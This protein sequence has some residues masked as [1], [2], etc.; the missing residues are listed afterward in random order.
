MAMNW[1][2]AL[3]TAMRSRTDQVLEKRE[4][5]QEKQKQMEMIQQVMFG[6]P[7]QTGPKTTQIDPAQGFGG[8][9]NWDTTVRK[10]AQA[11]LFPDA[12]PA[13][14]QYLTMNPNLAGDLI[15][16]Q[17]AEKLK[18]A[19]SENVLGVPAA[20]WNKLTPEQQDLAVKKKLNIDGDT[21][22]LKPSERYRVVG[23][24]LVDLSG[25][26]GKPVVAL[27][28]E[29]GPEGLEL[30]DRIEAENKLRDD[31][32]AISK[33]FRAVRDSFARIKGAGADPT[34]AG[35]LALIFNYMKLLDPGSVVRESEFAVAERAGGMRDRA[36][37]FVEKI[38]NG[39]RLSPQQ[40]ADFMQRAQ[41]L[42]ASM[43]GIYGEVEN[44]YTGMATR[45]GLDPQNV[46]T[47]YKGASEPGEW[48]STPSGTNYRVVE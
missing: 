47:S 29:Q 9:V 39:Q 13:M 15:K 31:F 35:D 26:E 25:P 24:R 38:R 2:D 14:K 18:G 21:A 16:T 43:Q 10:P 1:L 23:D 40:R 36:E 4:A 32:N 34:A 37:A 12:S 44:E 33:D 46:V 7:A 42:F 48:Q 41:K 19:G 27:E 17:M 11:G 5:E 22:G 6:S 45:Y 3:G 30:K 28:F 8:Q 20:I